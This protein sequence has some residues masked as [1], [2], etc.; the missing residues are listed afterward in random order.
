M[1]SPRASSAA[2][3]ILAADGEEAVREYAGAVEAV[4]LVVLDLRLP[5][6]AGGEVLRRLRALDPKVRVLVTSGYAPD[7]LDPAERAAVAGCITKPYRPQELARAVRAAL[8]G[9]N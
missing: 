5:K 2:R 9:K 8:D 1:G 4:D 6:L 3:K 7:R